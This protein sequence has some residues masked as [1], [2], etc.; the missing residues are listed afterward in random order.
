[1][2][3]EPLELIGCIVNRGMGELVVKLCAR[4]NIMFRI[5]LRGR[6]TAD[7]ETLNLL[8]IGDKEKD[9][10]FLSVYESRTNEIMQKL[11]DELELTRAGRGIAFSIQFSAVASQLSS[12][13][14][15]SGNSNPIIGPDT[16]TNAEAIAQAVKKGRQT[17]REKSKRIKSRQRGDKTE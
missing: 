2:E 17:M 13:D 9:V 8:G 12:Y 10:A 16:S 1:M 11:T 15:L 14:I 6:G 7:S 4:E 5:L 3:S